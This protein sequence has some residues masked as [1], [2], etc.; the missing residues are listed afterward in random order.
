MFY[1]ATIALL[2]FFLALSLSACAGVR[3][4][5]QRPT[6]E[7]IEAVRTRAEEA[8]RELKAVIKVPQPAPEPGDQ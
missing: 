4:A 2:M 5:V 7:E 1:H 8:S 3:P 6:E